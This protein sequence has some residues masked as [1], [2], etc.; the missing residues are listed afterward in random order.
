[1]SS[2]TDSVLGILG[3]MMGLPDGWR[4]IRRAVTPL[5]VSKAGVVGFGIADAHSPWL[6]GHGQPDRMKANVLVCQRPALTC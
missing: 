4:A 5:Q 6:D 2:Q 3:A 1:M